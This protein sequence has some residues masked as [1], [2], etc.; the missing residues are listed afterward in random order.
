MTL[1]PLDIVLVLPPSLRGQAIACSDLVAEK[2]RAGRSSSHFRLGKPFPG[3]AGDCEP[4]VSLF[5]LAV[6]EAEVNEVV[7]VVEGLAPRLPAL[8]AE[9]AEY[10]Y[11]PHGAV[12]VYFTKSPA[13]C[14]FQ[15]DVIRSVEPLRRGR[16]REVDPSGARL[17]D[18]VDNASH[19]DSRRQQ[20]L[21]YGYDEVADE[22]N[23]GCDRFN[24]HVTLAWPDD[25]NH[26]VAL[27]GL[28]SPRSFSGV[29]TELAVFGMSAYGTCTKN[30]GVFSL[31]KWASGASWRT[32]G[33]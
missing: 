31:K 9:G 5:M 12:E 21:R 27:D 6:A 29:L 16:L 7:R 10:R 2:M 32:S 30:Y 13:W 1:V 23:G 8:E 4:H 25:H 19:E 26:R 14:D 11:N 28:P 18:L 22:E 33:K 17:R 15:R 24:P 20:L 3:E